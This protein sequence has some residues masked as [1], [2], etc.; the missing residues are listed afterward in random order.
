MEVRETLLRFATSGKH[1]GATMF[2]ARAYGGLEMGRK[3]DA[4]KAGDTDEE[5]WGAGSFGPDDFQV[6]GPDGVRLD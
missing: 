1:A 3:R 6:F 4:K 2:W 5:P